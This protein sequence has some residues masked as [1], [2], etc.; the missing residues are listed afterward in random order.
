M[1]LRFDRTLKAPYGEAIS[2][3]PHI[4]RLLAPNPGPFT[5]KGTGVY[6]VGAGQRI[7]VIDPGPDLPDHIE[8]LQRAIGRREISHILITHTHRDHSPAAAALKEWSGAK[9]YAAGPHSAEAGEVE[10][11]ADRDFRPDVIVKDGAVIAGDGFTLTCVATP[12]HTANHMCYAL[13]EELALFCGD[14][15]MGWSTSVVAPPD[16]DMAAYLASLEKLIAREDRILYP[17]H[18][19]PITAPRDYLRE[20]RAHRLMRE[21]QIL[22]SLQPG[23]NTAKALAARLYPDIDRKLAVAAASQVQAHLEHLAKK[24]VLTA[25]PGARYARVSR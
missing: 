19:S 3:S 16:G 12:G 2:L 23:A 20:L 1:A 17:T 24:G 13:Q 14:H 6:L 15:V 7:A 22:E 21:A 25:L 8:A 11:G 5:F 18:G 4:A 9:T 10:E